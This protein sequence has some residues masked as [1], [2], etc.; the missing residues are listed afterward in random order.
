MLIKQLSFYF[1]N[2]YLFW[3]QLDCILY[4]LC[5][6]FNITEINNINKL[7]YHKK[8]CT[9][10]P[11]TK[12]LNRNQSKWIRNVRALYY[13]GN[14]HCCISLRP[15]THKYMTTY[16]PDLV[17]PHKKSGMAK[18]V[19]GPKESVKLFVVTAAKIKGVVRNHPS[20]KNRQIND[21]MN[22]TKIRTMFYK[23]RHIILRIEQHEFS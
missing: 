22:R 11:T 9:K 12:Y 17:Q 16:F 15:I 20:K 14:E 23:T 13:P 3:Q 2:C 5:I 1:V 10:R 8:T 18:L 19:L 21:Q 7:P 6:D 4:Y